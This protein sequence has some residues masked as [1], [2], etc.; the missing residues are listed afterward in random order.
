MEG[1]WASCDV[2]DFHMNGQDIH[3]HVAKSSAVVS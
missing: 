2:F 3:E 1:T